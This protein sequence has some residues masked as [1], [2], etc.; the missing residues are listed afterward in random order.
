MWFHFQIFSAHHSPGV[1]FHFT[2]AA[3]DWVLWRNAFLLQIQ[4]FNVFLNGQRKVCFKGNSFSLVCTATEMRQENGQTETTST[5]GRSSIKTQSSAQETWDPELPR[6]SQC[7]R[8]VCKQEYLS[9]L[10]FTCKDPPVFGVMATQKKTTKMTPTAPCPCQHLQSR[11]FFSFAKT[12]FRQTI[13]NSSQWGVQ[14]RR[15]FPSRSSDKG[16][17][18]SPSL[19]VARR[20]FLSVSM[21]LTS[22]SRFLIWSIRTF[23]SW[24]FWRT[25]CKASWEPI[26]VRRACEVCR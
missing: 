3:D 12:F 2:R 13:G 25:F 21:A 11:F 9:R 10:G 14:K 26:R 4:P 6:L 19:L 7:C 15:D 8:D 17:I 16:S 5:L 23:I 20:H 24:F 22:H 18:A 1:T